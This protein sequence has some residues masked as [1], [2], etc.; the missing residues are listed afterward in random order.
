MFHFRS[1]LSYNQGELELL[2]KDWQNETICLAKNQHW[3]KSN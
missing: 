3:M 2:M 1:V